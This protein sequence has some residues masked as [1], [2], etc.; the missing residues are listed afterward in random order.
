M[1]IHEAAIVLFRRHPVRGRGHRALPESGVSTGVSCSNTVLSGY[2]EVISDPTTPAR[3]FTFTYPHIGNY[4][5]NAHDDEAT[6]PHCAGVVVRDLAR[7]HSL[8]CRVRPG[9]VP[10]PHGRG[11]ASQ[12]ST[13]DG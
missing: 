2:Q 5:V 4:G 3:S 12:G 7:R 13:R 11:P 6:V 1:T 8:A 10:V 9:L